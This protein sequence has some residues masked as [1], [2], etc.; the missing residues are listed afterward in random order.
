MLRM[1]FK[2]GSGNSFPE[3]AYMLNN[4][5]DKPVTVWYLVGGFN[6]LGEGL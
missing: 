1:V 5:G 2:D 3:A 4:S 6:E